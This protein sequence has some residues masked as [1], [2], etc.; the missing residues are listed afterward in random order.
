MKIAGRDTGIPSHDDGYDGYGGEGDSKNLKETTFAG[1]PVSKNCKVVNNH[2]EVERLNDY[3]GKKS[4]ENIN[5]WRISIASDD[6]GYMS[7]LEEG[8]GCLQENSRQKLVKEGVSVRECIESFEEKTGLDKREE[9][10]SAPGYESDYKVSVTRLVDQFEKQNFIPFTPFDRKAVVRTAIRKK[11]NREVDLSAIHSRQTQSALETINPEKKIQHQLAQIFSFRAVLS[12]RATRFH[13]VEP[14][15]NGALD[16]VFVMR[17]ITDIQS[18]VRLSDPYNL[19]RDANM[20]LEQVPDVMRLVLGE[21]GFKTL[22]G[23]TRRD[24]VWPAIAENFWKFLDECNSLESMAK[25]KPGFQKC[26]HYFPLAFTKAIA[27]FNLAFGLTEKGVQRYYLN[28]TLTAEEKGAVLELLNMAGH[29]QN[30]FSEFYYHYEQLPEG[31]VKTVLKTVLGDVLADDGAIK[32]RKIAEIYKGILKLLT[33]ADPSFTPDAEGLSPVS[34]SQDQGSLGF[35]VKLAFEKLRSGL[36][37]KDPLIFYRQ[38]VRQ[39]VNYRK[40]K[41]GFPGVREVREKVALPVD[42]IVTSDAQC[43]KLRKFYEKVMMDLY[44]QIDS[45]LDTIS[46]DELKIIYK[47]TFDCIWQEIEPDLSQPVISKDNGCFFGF[48]TKKQRLKDERQKIQEVAKTEFSLVASPMAVKIA[49]MQLRKQNQS[50]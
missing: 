11:K 16:P 21:A 42:T 7:D 24:A 34:P 31:S 2:S 20:D 33:I 15:Q 47:T 50:R 12:G 28:S 9:L 22:R 13:D 41:E 35:S 17:A 39:I 27:K 25:R 23:E 14:Y 38:L 36:Q 6:S 40:E 8:D 19:I 5:E 43:E 46:D 1:I 26:E 30:K 32:S 45:I 48:K 37:E 18:F 29:L 4:P 49:S 44:D 10:K 3:H